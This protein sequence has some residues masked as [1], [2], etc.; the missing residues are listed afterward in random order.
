MSDAVELIC[1]NCKFYRGRRIDPEMAAAE[2]AGLLPR[3]HCQRFPEIVPK[4][5]SDWC[6][7]HRPLIERALIPADVAP[8]RGPGRITR[9]SS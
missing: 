2:R 8:E 5:D 9:R 4:H 1:G 7:E 3:G 6:G